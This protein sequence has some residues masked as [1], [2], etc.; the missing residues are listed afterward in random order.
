MHRDLKPG[1]T[2]LMADGTP[3][4]TD[5]GL[6]KQ[7]GKNQD[8]TRTGAVLGTPAYMAPEQARGQFKTLGPAADIYALGTILYEALAG[9]PPFV[10]E[11]PIETLRQVT[12][13]DPVPLSRI[14]PRNPRDL[15]TICLK[16]LEKEP[17]RRYQTAQ[18]LAYDL[19]RFL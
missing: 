10:G 3:K 16:C 9:R 8:Q 4:I 6:A 18:D 2:L 5:F 17:H 12:M 1:N 15:E 14:L 19:P 11:T 13:D 7:Q